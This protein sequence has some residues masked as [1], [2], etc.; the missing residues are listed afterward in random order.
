MGNSHR[1]LIIWQ[2]AKSL[3]IDIYRATERFPRREVFGITIQLRRAATSVP[4]NV[5]EGQGR[6]THGEF[7]Q[8]MNNEE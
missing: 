6:L 1:D 7:Y 2:R 8:R 4:S 5:A 3:A